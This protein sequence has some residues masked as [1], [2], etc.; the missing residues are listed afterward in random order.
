MAPAT[1][2]L[3][4]ECM[5]AR[6]QQ[7]MWLRQRPEVLEVLREQAIIQSAESSNRIEGVTVPAARLRPV[8]LGKSPPRD[9]PE[10][11]L[12]GY[13]S[14]LNWIFSRRHRI[15][16]SPEVIRK[17][18]LY[19]RGASSVDAGQYKVHDN[20]IIE[21]L[22]SG[23]RRVRFVPNSASE[24]PLAVQ[25]LCEAYLRARSIEHLPVL[26]LIATC[27]FDLLCIHPFRDGNGRVSRLLTTF[28]LEQEGSSVCRYVSLER[29]AE[30]RKEEYYEVLARCSTGW[31][32]GENDIVGWW[33]YFLSIMREAYRDF[34][35]KVEN[36]P[37][38]PTKS[39]LLRR[40]MMNQVGPF[41]LSEILIQVPS[42]SPQLAKKVLLALKQEGALKLTGRGRGA[43]WEVTRECP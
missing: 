26:P 25:T 35:Q 34:T 38:R 22:A 10:E 2:W 29:M 24:T 15:A 9:R 5:Q 1:A 40:T 20:K 43:L 3:L 41:T 36:A 17:M 12:A 13:R 18:H 42:A 16:L 27:V 31:H 11:E 19:A 32:E 6:G 28:L 39:E 23:E 33:N 7:E 14:A 8:V 4:G 37:G 30:E 21:T